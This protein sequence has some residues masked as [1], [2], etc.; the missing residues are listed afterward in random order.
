MDIVVVAGS[1]QEGV[2]QDNLTQATSGV[3]RTELLTQVDIAS[4]VE[5]L[6]QARARIG[7]RIMGSWNSAVAVMVLVLV[8]GFRHW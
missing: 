2:A 6:T 8:L 7:G 5:V 1:A 3:L 4:L